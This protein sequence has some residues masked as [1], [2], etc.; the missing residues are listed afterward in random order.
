MAPL[1]PF[2]SWA[3]FWLESCVGTCWFVS[4]AV[5]SRGASPRPCQSG[6]GW[7][8]ALGLAGVRLSLLRV[9]FDGLLEGFQLHDRGAPG[10]ESPYPMVPQEETERFPSRVGGGDAQGA[11]AAA[12]R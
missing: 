12:S 9:L 4:A 11:T 2:P 6:V 8:P 10:V 3:D 1:L 7:L 5:F